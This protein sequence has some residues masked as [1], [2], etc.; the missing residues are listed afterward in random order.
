MLST[1][2]QLSEQDKK[3]FVAKV[4]HEINYNQ[5]SY[6][7]MKLLVSY[8]DENPI[9]HVQYFPNNLNTTKRI[10]NGQSIN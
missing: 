10:N 3:L 9:N 8:W 2:H 7:L 5:A 4:L 1:F 6:N